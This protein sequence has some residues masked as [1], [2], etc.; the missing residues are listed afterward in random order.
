MATFDIKLY[1][2]GAEMVLGQISKDVY[3]FWAD[4]STEAVTSHI[5]VDHPDS[6]IEANP[7]TDP[8]SKVG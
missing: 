8:N 3:E 2:Y 7:V 5:F 4:Q 6:N 1:G